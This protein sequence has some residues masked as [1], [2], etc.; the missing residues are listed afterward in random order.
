MKT[1]RIT[2]SRYKEIKKTLNSVD[3]PEYATLGTKE[4]VY[5]QSRIKYVKESKNYKDYLI[6]KNI[7]NKY[8]NSL[9]FMKSRNLI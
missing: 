8:N 5:S 1:L 6:I 7:A 4:G 2:E 9:K 3:L